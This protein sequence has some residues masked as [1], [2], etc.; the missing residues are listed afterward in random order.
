MGI[1]DYVSSSTDSINR[2][3][4][5]LSTIKGL[6]W[7]SYDYSRAAV[8]ELH[9]AVAV[10]GNVV[11]E[12]LNRHLPDGET[13]SQIATNLVKNSA[14]FA[15]VEGVKFIPGGS[16]FVDIVSRSLPNDKKPKDRGLQE[17]KDKRVYQQYLEKKKKRNQW[18]GCLNSSQSYM[19]SFLQ[20]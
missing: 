10:N 1:W 19:K 3:A 17:L 18:R 4:P 6:C 14:Y 15:A 20:T 9:N 13:R 12:K 5:N 16:T 2:N 11:V 8:S 7:N